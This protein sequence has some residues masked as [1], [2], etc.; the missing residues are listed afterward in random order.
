MQNSV[1]VPS[2]TNISL[3]ITS[4][5][6]IERYIKALIH[7]PKRLTFAIKLYEEHIGNIG[8]KDICRKS[9]EAEC[10]L[11]IGE[12]CY[13]GMGFGQL[14]MQELLNMAFFSLDLNCVRL[15]VL[16][17]NHPAIK[18]YHR[19]GFIKESESRWHLDEFGQYWRILRMS[20]D[21]NDWR[22]T[23]AM[24]LLKEEPIAR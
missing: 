10:F 4:Q 18:I 8:L 14:A 24:N 13:R 6:F 16:E 5:A 22:P 1:I 9:G 21:K 3:D 19:L 15:D 7:D 20:I 17:F 2:R 11:E 23:P 12:K